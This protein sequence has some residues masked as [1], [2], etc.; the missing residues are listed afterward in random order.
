VN[1]NPKFF[2]TTIIFSMAVGFA[3]HIS[4]WL[5]IF[6]KFPAKSIGL[7]NLVVVAPTG[8]IIGIVLPFMVLY[9]MS[10]D[11]QPLSMYKSIIFSTFLGCWGGQITAFFVD[12]YVVYFSGGAYVDSWLVP[13]WFVWQTLILALSPIFFVC[14]GGIL[15]AYYQRTISKMEVAQYVET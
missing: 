15:F 9:F 14:L 5:F 7:L 11:A 10:R 3:S 6:Y 13:F 4:H 8:L 1:L 12:A 2:L